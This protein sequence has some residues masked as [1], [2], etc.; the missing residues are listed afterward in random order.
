[1][2]T[3]EKKNM[4]YRDRCYETFVSQHWKYVHVFSPAE[5]D[6]HSKLYAKTFLKH[7][8]ADRK[9]AVLDVACG[10]GHFM[11]FMKKQGYHN[12]AGIDISTEQI[13]MAHKMGVPEAREE[14]LFA[15]LSGHPGKY[16]LILA[17]DIIEHLHKDEVIQLLD[18]IYTALKPGG[19]VLVSTENAASLFGASRIFIDFTHE[20]GFTPISLKQVLRVCGF[21]EVSLHGVGPVHNL[22][23]L[24]RVG[25]WK[26][27]AFGLRSFLAIE[28]GLG[29]GLQ[30]RELIL[31]PRMFAMAKK[32][33]A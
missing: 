15:H 33:D 29:R 23:S 9:A 27:L 5:Y 2:Q 25:L 26:I 22:S 24:I 13:Q 16:D 10:A 32:V 4:N 20:W 18:G 31:E 17:N 28:S 3:I 11:Y 14:D 19:Q 7:L 21:A 1:M 8:P 6:F 12:L 30:K